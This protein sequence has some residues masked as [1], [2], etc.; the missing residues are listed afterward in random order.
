MKRLRN[1]LFQPV[2]NSQLI[3]FRIIFGFLITCEAWGAILTGWVHRA[4]IEPK[5]TFPFLDFDFLSPIPGNGM[6]YYFIV[7]G[8]FGL[9]VMLGFKYRLA[10]IG[11]ALM[12]SGVY[13][14]QK[15]NYNNHYYLMVLLTW[16]FTLL[17]SNESH[18]I[19][20]KY[21]K[22][23]VKNYCRQWHLWIFKGLVLIVYFYSSVAKMYPD[24]IH[25]VPIKIWF[26]QKADYPIV[27]PLLARNWFQHFVAWGGI[28][29]DLLIG[30]ALLWK[31]TRKTAFVASLFFHGFNS[32]VFQVGIF[33]FMGI[34]FGLFYFK[35]ETI[36][37]IFFKHKPAFDRAVQTVATPSYQS[38]KAIA[39]SAFMVL[40]FVLPLRHHLF[41][42]NVNWTEEGHRLSWRMMLRSKSGIVDVWVK[43]KEGSYY[44]NLNEYLT[45]KQ[46]AAIA[47]R[48]DMFWYF[49]QYLK[50][51]L[52]VKGEGDYEGLYAVSRVSLNNHPAK[53]LYKAEIDF[54]KVDW[55]RFSEN[56][57]VTREDQ[58]TVE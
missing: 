42:G 16:L 1:F 45:P 10:T 8:V 13:F 30:P 6:I 37:S 36:R 35:P 53:P 33:P 5:M 40:M 44:V 19:D 41:E 57:W 55:N 12:W 7:M 50:K 47:T 49:I 14:M 9:M 22:S 17:P 39:F 24:W 58:S 3:L 15:T 28:I 52:N 31:R 29:F 2:D 4:F 48:P 38:I 11:Y 27:G 34:A 43:K 21:N 23:I 51:D 46:Q 25:A 56:T 26:T 18:S 32:I 54:S 20:A